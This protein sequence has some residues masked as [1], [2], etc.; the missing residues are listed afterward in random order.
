[1]V[2]VEHKQSKPRIFGSHDDEYEVYQAVQ[3]LLS[4]DTGTQTD[5]QAGDLISLLSFLESSLKIMFFSRIQR[6]FRLV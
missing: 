4:G 6:I 5:R 1:M 2:T 3:R